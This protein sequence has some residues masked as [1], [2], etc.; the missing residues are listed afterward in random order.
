MTPRKLVVA[1]VACAL[2]IGAAPSAQK[3][4]PREQQ[5]FTSTTT[6]I[7]VD[8]VVRDRNGRPVVDL[9]ADDFSLAEDGVTQK[10]D[11]F[12][13][14]TRGGGIGVNVAW[15]TPGSDH[16]RVSGCQRFAIRAPR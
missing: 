9:S 4:T 1:S 15:R 16:R 12:S 6:A 7:L 11:S 8:V 14:V 5:S 10:V 13:R 2:A 3:P